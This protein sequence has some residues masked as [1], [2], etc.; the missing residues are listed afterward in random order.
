MIGPEGNDENIPARTGLIGLTDINDVDAPAPLD[1]TLSNFS[2][3][4]INWGAVAIGTGL[5][6]AAIWA[7]KKYKLIK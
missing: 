2:G 1:I 5:A 7:I 3:K 6:I 4:S